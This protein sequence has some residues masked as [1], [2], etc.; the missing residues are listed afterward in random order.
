MSRLSQETL[1]IIGAS[2]VLAALLLTSTA[3]VRGE[4]QAVRDELRGEIRD[5][6]SEI[7]DVPA[8]VHSDREALQAEARADRAMFRRHV[9][10][11]TEQQDILGTRVDGIPDPIGDDTTGASDEPAAVA[12]W[13]RRRCS[14]RGPTT[15]GHVARTDRFRCNAGPP[16]RAGM[17]LRTR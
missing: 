1:T 15:T 7:R 8:E 2:I 14:G 10:H 5:V 9:T 4:I 13:F 6:R 3:G 12:W 11:P 16:A 17:H